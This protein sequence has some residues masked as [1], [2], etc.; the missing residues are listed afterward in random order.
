MS[1]ELQPMVSISFRK[2]LLTLSFIGMT[3]LTGCHSAFIRATVVNHTNQ[4]I[5]L[6]ELDYPSASFGGGELAPG[7]TFRYRFK[8][9]GDGTTK[10]AWTDA[11]EHEHTAKGPT[12]QEGEE[13]ALNVL[14]E[15]TGPVWNVNLHTVK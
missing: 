8:V 14:I 12:L 11:A 2:C 5:R 7:A 9:I 1:P 4:P 13:G 6:F 3:A 10:L 15:P